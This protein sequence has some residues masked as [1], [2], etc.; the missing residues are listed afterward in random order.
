[1]TVLDVRT[2]NFIST[3]AL[4]DCKFHGVGKILSAEHVTRKL[5]LDLS[6]CLGL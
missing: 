3:I 2:F 5:L 1:V 6:E 4:T